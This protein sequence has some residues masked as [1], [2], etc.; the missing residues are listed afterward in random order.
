MKNERIMNP[1]KYAAAQAADAIASEPAVAA[2][3]AAEGPVG[4]IRTDRTGRL[5]DVAPSRPCSDAESSHPAA[6]D[7]ADLCA[8]K[9]PARANSEAAA[10]FCSDAERA[11]PAGGTASDAAAARRAEPSAA[12]LGAED[13]S[14][15]QEAPELLTQR[16]RLRAFVAEDAGA[17]YACCRNPRLGDDAGWKPHES[18]EESRQV[19]RE[20]FLAKPTVWAVTERGTDRLMGAVALMP[21]PKC[22]RPGTAML[23]YWLDQTQWGRGAMS[24]ACRC[25]VGY[26]F[27]TLGLERITATCYPHNLRSKRVI[28]RLGFR[29]D[30]VLPRAMRDYRGRVFDLLSYHLPREIWH[31]LP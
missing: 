31:H 27:A 3:H 6:G 4:G 22:D 21:D 9:T 5:V 20:V 11:H 7:G 13:A 10:R 15:P 12:G 24:E 23:G 26:G 30:G 2:A 18:P 8:G 16:L 14:R 28:E 25:V 1:E 19:L 17:V 29:F